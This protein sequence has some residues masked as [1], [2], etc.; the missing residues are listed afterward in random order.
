MKTNGA[1]E[2]YEDSELVVALT[3]SGLVTNALGGLGVASAK[4][5]DNVLL[6]LQLRS[7]DKDSL[8]KAVVPLRQDGKLVARA[9]Q[10]KWP[11][12]QPTGQPSDLDLLLRKL[13]EDFSFQYGGWMPDIGKNRI[14]S[15]VRGLPYV[16]GCT[17]GHP[18]QLGL[19]NPYPGVTSGNGMGWQEPRPTEP[20]HGVRVGLLDTYLYPNA[21]LQGGYLASKAQLLQ[22]RGGEFDAIEGHATFVAGL[23]LQ[24]APGATLVVRPLL[25]KNGLAKTW[26][27]AKVMAES[28]GTGVD[29]LNLSFGCYTDDGQPPLVLAKAVS[30]LSPRILLVAAAGNHGDIE[31]LRAEDS[32]LAAE[33]TKNLTDTTPVWP[34]AF[35][36]VTAVGATDSK[37]KLAPFS[38]K[39]PW[40]DATAPGV[41]VEST[42]L[43]GKVRIKDPGGKE[44]ILDFP[45]FARWTGTSFAAASVSGAIAAKIGPDCTPQQA[46]DAVLAGRGK[47]PTGIRRFSATAL[48]GFR[49]RSGETRSWHEGRFEP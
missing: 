6:G 44:Q 5:E 29:V 28:I 34:A 17:E 22:D 32:P 18:E 40:V 1:V 9:T 14:I 27:V 38:P 41:E 46:R 47:N 30:L 35:A 45:G 43:T 37:G 10:A 25:G 31:E 7:L 3:H 8:A 48:P 42:Y 49:V 39:A 19:E 12:R 36:E 23:I 21:W 24:R 26:Q 4:V 11:V 16:S 33:W 20:G 2:D 15:P 13:R